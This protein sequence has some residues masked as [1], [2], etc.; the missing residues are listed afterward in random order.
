MAVVEHPL[1]QGADHGQAGGTGGQRG[2]LFEPAP[3][4]AAEV[5][6]LAAEL[7]AKVADQGTE[8]GAHA[9]VPEECA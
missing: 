5:G 7:A 1:G 6:D 4:L 9:E 3:D 2:L 8:P